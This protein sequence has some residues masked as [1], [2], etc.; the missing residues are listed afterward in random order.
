[1]FLWPLL[2]ATVLLT[3]D[4]PRLARYEFERPIMGMPFKLTLYATDEG[5]A[6]RGAEAVFK[7]VEEIDQI[8]SDY[9]SESEASRLSAASPMTQPVPI[10]REM[11]E[12]LDAALKLSKASD[13]AFDVSIGP[14]TRLWRWSR[15]HKELPDAEKLRAAREAVDYQAI[16]LDVKNRTV[17]LTK[18]NMRLDFGGIACGYAVDE[19]LEILRQQGITSAMLDASGDIGLGDPPPGTNGWRIGI[20]HLEK[21]DGPPVCFVELARCGIT[22]SGDVFQFVQIGGVRYSHIVD[23]KTGLGMTV[24]CEA[25]VIAKNCLTADSYTKPPILNGPEKGF[26]LIEETPTAAAI[27]F[28]RSGDGIETFKTK[29]W[30]SYEAR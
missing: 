25:T 4:E 9:K 10:S 6:N 22:T 19:G 26:A 17:R 8:F 3:A 2:T 7:R 14:L 30:D 15:R 27:L 21:P 20:G 1:M 11:C 24:H 18:P 23:K 29:R 5:A 13:G 16:E 28:R 12:V